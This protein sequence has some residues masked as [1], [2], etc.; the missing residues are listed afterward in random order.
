M[1]ASTALS[2]GSMKGVTAPERAK[3][4]QA[5]ARATMDPARE[6]PGRR[7]Q[8]AI[9]RQVAREPRYACHRSILCITRR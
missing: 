8:R 7:P 5:M 6:P 3:T 4:S 1:R 2:G 9:S